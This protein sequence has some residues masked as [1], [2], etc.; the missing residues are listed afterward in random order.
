MSDLDDLAKIVRAE[1]VA[2]RAQAAQMAQQGRRAVSPLT[3]RGFRR[4]WR[5]RR[6]MPFVACNFPRR[7]SAGARL[8]RGAFGPFAR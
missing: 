5:Q 2:R 8:A 3:L 4:I 1:E 6:R 7:R